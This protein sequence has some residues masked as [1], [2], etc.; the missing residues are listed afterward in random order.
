MPPKR[1]D[2]GVS[3]GVTTAVAVD[4]AEPCTVIVNACVD[5]APHAFVYVAVNTFVPT[6]KGID[7]SSLKV[8]VNPLGPDQLH[9]PPVTG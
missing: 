6:L 2:I 4:V 9:V 1:L 7:V 5:F 3:T 8:D